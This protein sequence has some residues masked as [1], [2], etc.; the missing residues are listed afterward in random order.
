MKILPECKQQ[1]LS[2]NTD[3]HKET[4]QFSLEILVHKTKHK[5]KNTATAINQNTL[6]MAV[7]VWPEFA[8]KNQAVTLSCLPPPQWDG[9]ENQ[10]EKGKKLM[11]WDESS[12]TAWQREKKTAINNTDPKHLQ[13]A[14]FSP[15]HAQLA[16]EQQKPLLQPAPH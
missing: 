13:C 8:T 3:G 10:K 6:Y 11:T 9:E 2:K 15:P 16:P 5:K 14:V 1:I 12:L 7:T 4:K